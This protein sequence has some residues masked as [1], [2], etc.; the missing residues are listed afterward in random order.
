MNAISPE[1]VGCYHAIVKKRNPFISQSLRSWSLT[2]R[3]TGCN[4]GF[5]FT[6][7]DDMIMLMPWLLQFNPILM[8]LYANLVSLALLSISLVSTCRRTTSGLS[9]TRVGINS[10]QVVCF[11]T[12]KWFKKGFTH[13]NSLLKSTR[14]VL[15]TWLSRTTKIFFPYLETVA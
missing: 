10:G 11:C 2:L 4:L 7:K 12:I 5:F 15:L 13:R 14:L 9:S 3:I 1:M 8:I 6:N